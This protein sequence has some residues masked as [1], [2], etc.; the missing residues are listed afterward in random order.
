M[1]TTTNKGWD[2]QADSDLVDQT[3]MANAFMDDLDA[4]LFGSGS[5]GSRPAS[6][7]E[8]DTFYDTTLARFVKYNGSAWI[9]IVPETLV[10]TAG[11]LL[12]ASGSS[13]LTRLAVGS[14]NTALISNGSAPSWGS[15]ATAHLGADAVTGTKLADNAVDSEHYTD[16][17]I[18]NAHLAADSVTNAKIADD[19]LDSE[20]YTDGSIDAA[21]LASS[22]VT[23]A[24]INA[25]AVTSAKIADNA[26]DSEHYTDGSID[27]AHIAD[28]ALDS[29]HYTDG[30]IDAAHLSASAVTAAK[31]A[32]GGIPYCLVR[33]D[34]TQ[35]ISN[36]TETVLAWNNEVTDPNGMHDNSTNNSQIIPQTAG[37]YAPFCVG[38][39]ASNSSGVRVMYFRRNGS[40]SDRG[41]GHIA[42]PCDG[43]STILSTWSGEL[44]SM[45]GSSDYLEVVV[46]Q[47]SGGSLDWATDSNSQ[48]PFFGVVWVGPADS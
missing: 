42:P 2:T 43:D 21:H 34:A 15:I 20:H 48:H 4:S 32:A 14:A 8:G 7:D 30:S 16:G 40:G 5:T 27:N 38:G 12:Y 13:V 29:E 44:F 28:D 39:W 25:D 45:N 6:P 41:W 35:S 36:S 31:F 37:Y 19:A 18:D 26:I 47:S 33:H 9:P 17:S 1:G 11:D 24:K 46:S 10:T 3:T 22:A 23:T